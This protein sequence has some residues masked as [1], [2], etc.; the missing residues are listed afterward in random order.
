[1]QIPIFAFQLMLC[2]SLFVSVAKAE[3]LSVPDKEHRQGMS[4]EE[5]SNYR[6]KMRMHMER[7][8]PE[9]RKQAQD[10]SGH[11]PERME[12][13]N[14]DST[15]GQGYHSRHRAEDRPDTG[16]GNRPDHPRVER[17]NRGDM[18]HR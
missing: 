13:H 6:E 2:M 8:T 16:A 4:Y 1:M 10:S 5:Y 11:P 15:Y 3:N 18:G 17:F 14:H 9:E 12:K 7:M